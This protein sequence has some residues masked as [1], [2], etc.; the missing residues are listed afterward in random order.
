ME[1]LTYS[2]TVHCCLPQDIKKLDPKQVPLIPS[3]FRKAP[4]LN[5]ALQRFEWLCYL[6]PSKKIRKNQGK[7]SRY[8]QVVF[9][10]IVALDAGEQLADIGGTK[11]PRWSQSGCQVGS[12]A[13]VPPLRGSCGDG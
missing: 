1:S 10:Q 3:W 4:A 7:G 6:L 13:D 8:V 2:L 12:R 11:C 9:F 5:V